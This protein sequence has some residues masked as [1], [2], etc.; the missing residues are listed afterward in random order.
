MSGTT[1]ISASSSP[2]GGGALGGR[3]DTGPGNIATSV[4]IVDATTSAPPITRMFGRT[5]RSMCH[6]FSENDNGIKISCESPAPMC[7]DRRAGGR[8]GKQRH[9]GYAWHCAFL[10]EPSTIADLG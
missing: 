10:I 3:Y 6:S 5:D 4:D 1:S 2:A 7:V 9:A 8:W